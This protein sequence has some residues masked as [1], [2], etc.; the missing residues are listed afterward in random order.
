MIL[1]RPYSLQVRASN[2][3]MPMILKKIG[4]PK[5]IKQHEYRVSMTP[6]GVTTLVTKGCDVFVETNAGTAAGFSDEAYKVAGA[7]IVSKKEVFEYSDMIVKVKE[8]LPKEFPLIKE[9]QVIFTFFHFAGVYGLEDE[10]GHAGAICIAYET[11]QR[12][13]GYLP[14][15]APMSEVAGRLAIQEGMR[16]LT[17]NNNGK[18]LLL[19]GIPG[20][21]PAKV[22]VIGAG[23]VGTNAAQLAAGLGSRVYILDNNLEKLRQ[24]ANT[25]PKNVSTIY[26]T[27]TSITNMLSN[28]DLVVGGVLIPGKAAPKLVSSNM[29]MNMQ[30]GSVFVDVAIDQGGMTDVSRPTSHDDPVF[31]HGPVTMYCVANMPGIVPNTSTQG[32][33]NAT[34]PYIV[35]LAND[36]IYGAVN[37]YPELKPAIT[38]QCHDFK[39]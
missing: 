11:V 17:K 30:E 2:I 32:L 28:A 7:S 26:S 5:E 23:T 14:I 9:N 16:F 1:S 15:L 29:L 34:L 4:V 35:S 6:A 3:K 20:V 37:K 24:L 18:G 38:S 19:S 21:E 10:M 12:E 36:G 33:T 13:G 31:K 22:V 27:E 39:F 8:P 25:M